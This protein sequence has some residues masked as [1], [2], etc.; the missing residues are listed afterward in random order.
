MRHFFGF[1]KEPFSADIRVE[2]LFH[3]AALEGA[4]ER[5]LY[6]VNLGAISVIT[7]DV[8]SGK[9]TAIRYAA[10]VLHPS[11]YQLISV[12]ASTGS[13]IEVLKQICRVLE[14][15]WTSIS[16]AKLMRT[17]RGAITEIG[18]RRQVP[19]LII[20]E[21]SLLRIEVFAP[22]ARPVR[23][24]LKATSSHHTGRPE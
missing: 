14:V 7:G 18:K 24:G 12:V 16:L 21:A 4:K 5:C 3:T 23:Y 10:S 2:E 20:D 6:A 19:V 9:S 17:V 11:Q 1:T 8:G 15:E 13:I 22:Y